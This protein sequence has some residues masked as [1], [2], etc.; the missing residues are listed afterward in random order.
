[1]CTKSP[2]GQG[3]NWEWGKLLGSMMANSEGRVPVLPL[4]FY[5][6]RQ[7]L[8]AS[9]SI[10]GVIEHFLQDCW[11]WT[12]LKMLGIGR[13]RMKRQKTGDFKVRKEKNWYH[14]DGYKSL[15]ICLNPPAESTTGRVNP[16][17]NHGFG[18][19]MMCPCK[20]ISF[21]RSPILVG[22]VDNGER[23]QGYMRTLSPS[24]QLCFKPRTPLKK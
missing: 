21:N 2:L 17:A 15:Y 4:P 8:C 6:L 9:I 10:K 7:D 3:E 11:N 22:A 20:L 19:T 5:G 1:M 24:P 16:A 13:G 14:N 18:V 23:R 12:D